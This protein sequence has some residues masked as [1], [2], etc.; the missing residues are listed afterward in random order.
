M[1]IMVPYVFRPNNIIQR[2][3]ARS[4]RTCLEN[5]SGFDTCY[6]RLQCLSRYI[7]CLLTAVK[8]CSQVI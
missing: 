3:A 4:P 2:V 8:L 1:F 5:G 7:Q 6:P